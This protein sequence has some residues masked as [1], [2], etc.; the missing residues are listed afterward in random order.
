VNSAGLVELVPYNLLTWSNDFTNSTWAKANS[1]IISTNNLGPDG[2][3]TATRVNMPSASS[4]QLYN[5]FPSNATTCTTSIWVRL[6]SGSGNF[7]LGFYDN[8]SILTNSITVTT[9]WQ[10]FSVTKTVGA[11]TQTRGCWLYSDET[12]QVIEIWGGQVVEGTTAKDY[13]K[14]ETRLN[15]PRLDYSN[16][17]C[18][19]LLVEPQRTNLLTYSE[20]FDNASWVKEYVSVTVNTT[21][22]PNGTLTADS[23]ANNSIN[24][25]HRF[26]QGS[27]ANLTNPQ[28]VTFSAY[29][30]YN[31]HRY[32]SFGLTDRL[33][34]RSQV[35][36]DLLNGVIT[37]N[38]ISN[39]SDSLTST[40]TN[41]GNGWYRVTGTFNYSTALEGGEAYLLGTLLNQSTFTTNNYVGTGT[42]L[43]IW[44]TQLEVG[45]YPT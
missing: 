21:T 42:S 37:Q 20:Q 38:Y 7:K 19:S 23:I 6:V 17:T 36:I 2:T 40:I 44:G 27:I 26:Y 11:F 30:K 45:S 32:F 41:V 24:N 14:T 29:L 22:S 33:F 35:V 43:F 9:T 1:T 3:L 39:V 10:R 13:Q 8:V 5:L 28:T 15:I 31:N 4:S 25:Y 12:N 34:Y 18:P 16:G